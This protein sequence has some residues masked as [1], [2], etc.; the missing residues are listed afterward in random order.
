M[1]RISYMYTL[2]YI[3]FQRD[4]NFIKTIAYLVVHFFIRLNF[5][6]YKE[7]YLINQRAYRML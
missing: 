6:N 1:Q 4:L 7:E 2:V 5:N 3:S